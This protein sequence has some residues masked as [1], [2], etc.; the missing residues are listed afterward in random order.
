MPASLSLY[1]IIHIGKVAFRMCNLISAESCTYE[2]YQY[3]KHWSI[4]LHFYYTLDLREYCALFR[5]YKYMLD[6]EAI[7]A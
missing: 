1:L 3:Y 4:H 2:E 7:Y 5:S 6:P